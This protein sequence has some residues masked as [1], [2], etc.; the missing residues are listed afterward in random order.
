MPNEIQKWKH[1]TLSNSIPTA[2]PNRPRQDQR[3]TGEIILMGY[4]G[5]QWSSVDE[6]EY[7]VEVPSFC[8]TILK[9]AD[10]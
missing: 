3:A 5:R 9:Y 8:L 10:V 1:I 4:A 7:N 6:I 2:F